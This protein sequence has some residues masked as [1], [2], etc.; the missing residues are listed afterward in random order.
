MAS[1]S[2]IR[3]ALSDEGLVPKVE[4]LSRPPVQAEFPPVFLTIE[5]AAS[6][7]KS[8]YGV[9]YRSVRAGRVKG[10]RAGRRIVIALSDLLAWIS[11]KHELPKNLPHA[12]K[13]VAR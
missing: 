8:S 9:V 4:D 1:P 5:E 11:S 13:A 3:T 12:A 10:G 7:S 6:L 2:D